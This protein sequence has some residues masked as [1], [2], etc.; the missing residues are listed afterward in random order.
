MREKKKHLKRLWCLLLILAMV[1]SMMPTMAF[2]ETGE[3]PQGEGTENHPYLISDAE[4]LIWFREQVNEGQ[5]NICGKLTTDISLSDAENWTPIGNSDNSKYR[6]VF[7]GGGFEISGLKI[8]STQSYQ[9]LFGRVSGGSVKNLTV[10]GNVE[11]AVATGTNSYAAGLVA[12][13]DGANIV[14]CTNKVNVTG[15]KIGVGGIAGYTSGAT[16][17]T[18]CTNKG[19]IVNNGTSTAA[20]GTGGIVGYA[21]NAASEISKC[22]NSGSITSTQLSTG[23]IAGRF[24]GSI[25]ESFNTGTVTGIL[26]TGGI[27]GD[28]NGTSDKIEACYNQGAIKGVEN[29]LTFNNIGLRT[30]GIGGILGGVSANSKSAS[31]GNSYNTG[32][33]STEDTE[34]TICGGLVG[35]SAGKAM[36]SLSYTAGKVTLANSYYLETSAAQGDGYNSDTAGITVKTAAE[37]KAETFSSDLAGVFAAKSGDYPILK[38]QDPDAESQIIFHITPQQAVLTVKKDGQTVEPK[39]DRTY[40]LKNGDYTYQVTCEDFKTADGSFTV[41]A[42]DQTIK[43]SLEEIKYPFTFTTEPDNVELTVEGEAAPA[44]GKNYQLPKSGNPYSYTAKA[45]GYE[46]TEGTFNI[47][48]DEEQDKLT[49]RLQKQQTYQV[50][51]PYEKESGGPA[52]TVKLD[53]KSDDYP[54]AVIKAENQEDNVFALPKGTYTY[55]VVCPGYKTVSGSFSVEDTEL[56][57]EKAVLKIQI[58]W[59][60]ETLDEPTKEDGTYLIYTVN[61]LMWFNREAALTDSAKLMADI[62]INEDVDADA[63]ELYKWNPLGIS[64]SKAYTGIFD[65]NGHK[66]SGLYIDNG[67]ASNTGFIGYMGASGQVKNLTISQSR[68]SSTGN[69]IGA[70][71]GDSKGDI[72]NCHVTADVK[73]SGKGYVGGIVGELDSNMSL[74]GCSNAGTVTA[75]ESY[76]GGIAG[77]IYSNSSLAL[78]NSWNKG[79]VRGKNKVGGVTGGI[80]YGGTVSNVYNTGTV[81]ADDSAGGLVGELRFGNLLKAYT[82]GTVTAPYNG[83][84]IGSLDFQ[85]G[86][87]SLDTVFYK[88]DVAEQAIGKSG[89]YSIQSGEASAKT[90]E[91][92]KTL[93]S[94]LGEAFAADSENINSGYPVLAW[95]NGEGAGE[96]KPESDPDGWDG[97]TATAPKTVENVYQ[98]GTAAELK[99]FADAVKTNKDIKGVLTADVNL[100]HQPWSAIGGNDAASAFAGTFDGNGYTIKNLYISGGSYNGLFGYN[101]G[102]I[103]DLHITGLIRKSDYSGGAAAV[104]QGV[105]DDIVSEVTVDGGNI[106]AGIAAI[107][108]TG[109]EIK[110]CGNSGSISGGQYVGGVA[111]SNK[112]A[113]EKS[114]NTGLISATGSFAAGIAA[115]NEEGTVNFCANSGHIVGQAVSRLAFVGGVIGR[116]DGNGSNLYNSGNIAGLGSGIGGCIGVNTT[117]SQ[118]DKIYSVGD[119]CGAYQYNDGVKEFRVGGAVGEVITGVTNA[120]Y[121][122]TLSIAQSGSKGGEKISEAE[123]KEKAKALIEMLGEKES[124]NGVLKFQSEPKVGESAEVS[125]EGNGD[126]L[127]YVWY[128]LE[129]TAEKVIA[130]TDDFQVP[131]DLAGKEL[132]VKAMDA[133][134]KGII[135]A[136]PAQIDGFSGSVKITGFPVV[137]H[138]L[139]AEFS[140]TDEAAGY[141]WYRGEQPISGAVSSTYTV[142]EDDLNKIL[143]VRVTG[144]KPGYVE[145]ATS[146]VKTEEAVGIWPSDQCSQPEQ[147]DGV[148]QIG[149]AAEL[150]W[151][152]SQV[153]GGNYDLDAVLTEDIDVSAADK[154]YPIGGQNGYRGKFDGDGHTVKYVLKADNSSDQGFFSIITGNSKVSSLVVDCGITVTGAESLETGGIAGIV[155]G[156]VLGCKVKGTIAGGKMVGGFCG[157]LDVDAKIE[158]CINEAAVSGSSEVGGI[159]GSNSK[160]KIYYSINKGNVTAAEDF[161][162]GISGK[163]TNYAETVGCYN[164]GAV[165]GTKNVGGITGQSYVTTAPQGCYNIG[166]VTGGLNTAAVQGEI[167]GTDYIFLTTGSFYLEGLSQDKTAKAVTEADMKSDSFLT[168]INGEIGV[169][170][171]VKDVLNQNQGYPILGWEIGLPNPGEEPDNPDEKD[172][173]DVTFTLIG[174]TIHKDGEHTGETWISKVQLSGLPKGTTALEVFDTV[175]KANGYTYDITGS[176]YVKSITKPGD[177]TLSE[178]DNG[179][180]SGWMYTINNVFPDYMSSV[181][182]KD[183]DDM[184]F[185]YVDD[186]T[187][188]GW[189][190]NGKP[191]ESEYNPSQPTQS[192]TEDV[193]AAVK[194]GEGT[195]SVSASDVDKL[196]DS[197]VKSDASVIELNVKGADSADKVTVELPKDSVKSI[198]DKTD[199]ALQVN[200]SLGNVEL[201]R[202]AMNAAV[203]AASGSDLRIV[204]EKQTVTDQQ[205]EQLGEEAAITHVSLWSGDKE[206]TDLG[207]AKITISLPVADSQKD[208]T[209]AAAYTDEKGNLV[210]V[211]GKTVTINGKTYYQIETSELGT[212][213]LAEETKLDAAIAAQG[214]ETDAKAEKIKAGVKATKLVARSKAYK[215]KTKVYWT[216][217]WGY[218]VDGYNVYKSTKKN[219]GYVFMGKTK[220]MYM[221]HTKNL[222]KGT[223]YYYYVRGYRTVNGEKVYTQKSLRAIRTTK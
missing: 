218:K 214:G 157:I 128:V 3:I 119:V 195:A 168:R 173:I 167:D 223:R 68:I 169:T 63:G 97:T 174:D 39:S 208:K 126:Q 114:V 4:D 192:V 102:E 46:G 99:W 146:T 133:G 15:N 35:N 103:K 161:A 110:N 49:V 170:Y 165:S 202:A 79:D 29:N 199:A 106:V 164:T 19:S 221:Y 115:D 36:T 107:N 108:E 53:V 166:T 67:T 140:G 177:I 59:D 33:I 44:D 141:Q 65:G 183:G 78:D 45:F 69:Y 26:G 50:T 83:A 134:L 93:A 105:L 109:G 150:K 179:P 121:L 96:D 5:T 87:K 71:A 180:N 75:T 57:L 200:T 212:F 32:L 149:T 147:K 172:Y 159:A 142:T 100:N 43:I 185:R 158:N 113:I 16:K 60:G 89:S 2:A 42:A 52:G 92:L 22:G 145:A 14:N 73:V 72:T 74:S 101:I 13:A 155:E 194:D 163:S 25:T 20:Y 197:A 204:L 17:I 85:N 12:S 56:T 48:G 82:T 64:S 62:T 152:A 41:A 10:S 211:T 217:S 61:E 181:R 117:G 196:I 130:I 138:T 23:G 77:R 122:E 220:K 95:Q 187:T 207:T 51:I 120:Y 176:G 127:V 24:T 55:K 6:G 7:D 132:C 153:N 21:S 175:L 90:A 11:T 88:E 70:V 86:A 203:S 137:G 219:S 116:N 193:T 198:A 178:L 123:I 104:N 136:Q 160:G 40:S 118:A 188:T 189:D 135:E 98:I 1:T 27:A 156:Q 112:G 154:W 191:G 215:G 66:I 186:Y 205:K 182:M 81:T 125:Y 18:L 76:A 129:E 222:K 58:S 131:V 190:P 31:I 91:E 8:E 209:L 38:W 143:K 139:T 216:K 9:G 80:Y 34:N 184:I 210:K 148:Y 151:F 94:V 206:I 111:A 84:A 30:N 54:N 201:N 213:T 162:G 47:S 37:M 144:E 124:I 28:A 171:F